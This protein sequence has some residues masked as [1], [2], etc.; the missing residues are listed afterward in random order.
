MGSFIAADNI[1][2]H[3]AV[4]IG[5]LERKQSFDSLFSVEYGRDSPFEKYYNFK[6]VRY[7]KGLGKDSDRVSVFDSYPHSSCSGFLSEA[8]I[9]DTILVFANGCGKFLEGNQC[10]RWAIV[11]KIDIKQRGVG[12]DRLINESEKEFINEHSNWHDPGNK[13]YLFRVK[14]PSPKTPEPHLTSE[15]ILLIISLLANISLFVLFILITGKRNHI[16]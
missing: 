16:L 13:D 8:K 5:V 6:V 11:S 1:K 3:D 9:G 15:Q 4:F 10:D 7:Y 14:S 12:V 2:T